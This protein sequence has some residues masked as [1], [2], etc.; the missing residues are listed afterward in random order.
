MIQILAFGVSPIIYCKDG[1][2][3]EIF[4]RTLAGMLNDVRNPD[5]SRRLNA[6][7]IPTSQAQIE[8]HCK[9][10][11]TAIKEMMDTA[12]SWL[13]PTH[14]QLN[15]NPARQAYAIDAYLA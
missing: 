14:G 2:R 8:K 10:R 13:T 3:A 6:L 5:G 1:L 12:T 7:R 4:A 9:M 11:P 15:L